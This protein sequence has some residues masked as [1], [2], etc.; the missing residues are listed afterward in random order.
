MTL[1]KMEILN[2]KR[3]LFLL[4][5]SAQTHLVAN[6]SPATICAQVAVT[7]T[8]VAIPFD[9]PI[10]KPSGCEPKLKKSINPCGFKSINKNHIIIGPIKNN[11]FDINSLVLFLFGFTNIAI[12]KGPTHRV[13]I[14]KDIV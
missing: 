5:P 7:P 12:Q 2:S 3:L 14:R 4:I 13:E 6:I 11:G 10:I 8:L 1:K 9:M